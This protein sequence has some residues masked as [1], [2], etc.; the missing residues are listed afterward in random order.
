MD[1]SRDATRGILSGLIDSDGCVSATNI[2]FA[3]ISEELVRQ[4]SDLALKF[5]AVGYIDKRE[6]NG[7][8]GSD[9]HPLYEV[10]WKNRDAVLALAGAL[11]L[12]EPR[13]RERLERLV[14]AKE[15][16]VSRRRVV[17][18]K[19]RV[20]DVQWDRIVEIQYAGVQP[21][22]CVTVEPSHLLVV[23][24]FVCRNSIGPMLAYN[25]GTMVKSGTPSTHKNNFYRSIQRN[26]RR[27]TGRGV[28]RHHFE[29]D[30]K[31]VAKVNKNYG[32]FIQKEKLRI[33]E[34]S[35][36]FQLSYACR[37]IL[38]RGMFVTESVMEHLS[39]KSQEVVRHW[40]KS[41]VIVGIDPARKL[42]S[43]VVTVVWVDWDR[44]DEFG[45]FDHRVLNWLELQGE[46]WEEQYAR[47]TEFLSN[48][49]VLAVGVD[50]N[51]V[52]DA[53]AQRL[54]V[55][56]PR[57]EVIPVTS[58]NMEQSSRFKHLQALI[59]RQL[60]GWPGHAKTRRLRTHKRFMQQMID[61][62]RVYSGPNFTV[63]APNE[64]WA[65]DD[66]VDSLAIACSLTRQYTMPS[67]EV[68]AN[69]FFS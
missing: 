66:Y 26:K 41:P 17:T 34:D 16:L 64:A 12:R 29:W 18:E 60:I 40:H 49:D 21:T 63:K 32:K 9:P 36:E 54:K 5:G 43:T 13:K 44:P 38:E 2:S 61:A 35:D 20:L 8:F 27:E 67:I 47:I 53:V 14:E 33:G 42:D 62:E 7:G 50:A 19:R 11:S 28:R 23:D 15:S 48:Y 69:P 52:G 1:Y 68:S 30:W 37:W 3:N 6:Q 65:H 56:L 57:A 10:R 4:V 25:S 39:D 22:Y 58:S 46:D 59:Q 51:G 55:L 45:Y 31:A 24:G